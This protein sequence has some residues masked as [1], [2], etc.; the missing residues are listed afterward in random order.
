M[1]NVNN[2]QIRKDPIKYAQKFSQKYNLTLLLKGAPSLV[3]GSK[4]EIY[5]NSNGNPG[6]ASGGTGD[7]LTGFIAGLLAQGMEHIKAAYTASY[8]H[9]LCAD[10]LLSNNTIYSITASDLIK[11]IGM[12]TKK[13][14][15]NQEE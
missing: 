13:Q 11:N 2:E 10:E 3:S 5:I 4:E 7:V 8:L 1:N 6:L 12:V 15:F 14:F 9:G